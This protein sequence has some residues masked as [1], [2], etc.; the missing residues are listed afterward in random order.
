MIE[1]IDD[2]FGKLYRKLERVGHF[3][4]YPGHF[5]DGHGGTV[6]VKTFNAAC[7]DRKPHPGKAGLG[8]LPLALASGF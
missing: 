6:G 7:T 3:E 4:G 5:H 8:F 2:N 1:N